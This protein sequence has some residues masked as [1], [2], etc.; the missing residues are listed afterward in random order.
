M[1]AGATGSAGPNHSRSRIG[2]DADATMVPPT[3]RRVGPGCGRPR[4]RSTL[5]TR[6]VRWPPAPPT[7]RTARSTARRDRSG[8]RTPSAAV[9]PGIP[10]DVVELA[11]HGQRIGP[12][13]P[14]IDADHAR[15]PPSP[16]GR[17]SRR[18]PWRAT[19]PRGGP[20]CR[21]VGA[22][23]AG[24]CRRRRWSLQAAAGSGI[25][26]DRPPEAL[27]QEEQ[28]DRGRCWRGLRQ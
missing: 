26:Q 16:P 28:A 5:R 10:A 24:W 19:A 22:A 21:E 14:W 17:R 4:A 2:M 25:G 9:D 27:S 8:R 12:L 7:R 23:C 15:R 11:H 18:G 3:W 13:P 1:T 20:R 6:H